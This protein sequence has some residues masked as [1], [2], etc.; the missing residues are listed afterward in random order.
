MYIG[1]VV[2]IMLTINKYPLNNRYGKIVYRLF[3]IFINNY[4]AQKPK[5]KSRYY[6]Y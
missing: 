3:Y 4:L 6:W 1:A 2:Y 5:N